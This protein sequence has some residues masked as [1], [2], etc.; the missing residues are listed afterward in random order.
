MKT[1]V[2]EEKDG[3]LVITLNR[4]EVLNSINQQ[5]IAEFRSVLAESLAKRSVRAL[6][7][8]GAGRA[9]CAGADL[10]ADDGNPA[11]G[12]GERVALG[13]ERGFNP[14]IREL[15][16]F[17][18]PT[19]ASVHGVAAG[20]GVGLALSCDIVLAARSASFIQ[21]FGPKLAIVPDMGCSW[22]LPHLLGRARARALALTGDRLSAEDAERWGLI[23]KCV[24]DDEIK[25]EAFGLAG[26][27]ASGPTNAFAWI[28]RALDAA[29]RN[30]LTDQ[31]DYEKDC[32]RVLADHPNFIEGVQAF[33]SKRVPDFSEG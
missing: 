17:P 27:L 1:L 15:A 3:V 22:F 9:F 33:L 5:L 26:R 25:S 14:L 8:T 4:P 13:M 12:V 6:L 7:V 2:V 32:Q 16:S 21:V 11:L 24:D 10:A 31:L 30:S 23:W 28:K 29:P 20:G 19:V 18:K